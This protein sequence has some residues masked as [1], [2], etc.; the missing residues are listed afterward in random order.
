MKLYRLQVFA[1]VARHLSVTKAARELHST[2]PALSHHLKV[3]RNQC[4]ILYRQDRSGIELTQRGWR[5]LEDIEPILLRIDAIGKKYGPKLCEATFECLTVG[6]SHGL[7]SSVTPALLK[8]FMKRHPNVEL[9]LMSGTSAEIRTLILESHVDIALVTDPLPSASLEME[10]FGQQTLS[11]FVA[12]HHPLAK[13]KTIDAEELAKFPLVVQRDPDRRNRTDELLS[14]LTA[15]GLKPDVFMRC[16]SPDAIKTV[17]R[18]GQAVGIHYND[19]IEMGA[20]KEK[21]KILK[22]PG[23]NPT[24]PSY[25]LYS[26]EKPL[27]PS[28]RDFV[29]LLRAARSASPPINKALQTVN[30]FVGLL[31]HGWWMAEPVLTAWAA[32]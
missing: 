7:L 27:A 30:V 26:K 15:K 28:A 3:L 2:Q 12:K 1:A 18:T 5:F 14:R 9:G 6:G 24:G 4:G 10:P 29:A 32:E 16:D 23:M 25:I 11:P 31:L 17:V 20:Q 21:F 19:V 13:K 22:I 8:T